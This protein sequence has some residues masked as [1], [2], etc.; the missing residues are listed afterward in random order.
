MKKVLFFALI[1]L[2]WLTYNK[3]STKA[4]LAEDTARASTLQNIPLVQERHTYPPNSYPPSV[5]A[6]YLP[7]QT[8][9]PNAYSFSF[10][11][12]Q[13]TLLAEFDIEAKVLS[14]EDYSYDEA[15]ALSPV[16]FALGWGRMSDDKVIE[17][18]DITQSRRWY[19]WRVDELP[20]P[21]REIEQSS[22]NM[23]M[24]PAT[25][26]IEAILDDVD[27]GDIVH[28][29]GYLMRSDTTEGRHWVSS[30]TRDDTGGGACEIIFV[31]DIR[32]NNH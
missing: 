17:N 5:E 11:G 7:I 1:I 23:H 9:L 31:Q 21:R 22:A 14:R 26:K 32:I 19:R 4:D 24:V 18:L 30:L 10:K 16:D 3:I 6:P 29:R 8:K 28:I 27:E 2:S 25:H 20:I 13:I 15:S 12:Q